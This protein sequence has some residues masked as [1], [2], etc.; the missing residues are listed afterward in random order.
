[1]SPLSNL[2][3]LVVILAGRLV[4]GPCRTLFGTTA[5]LLT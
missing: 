1:L 2:V 5:V 3:A 4:A